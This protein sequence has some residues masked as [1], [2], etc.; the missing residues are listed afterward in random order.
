MKLPKFS[1]II[2]VK[3]EAKNLKKCL[4]TIRELNYP[5]E[6]IET[7]IADG[8][9]TDQTKIIA[10]KFK[11]RIVINKKKTVAPGRNRGFEKSH[12]Q[13]IAFTDA[14]CL[15]DKNWLKQSL[16]YFKN[17]KIAGVGGPNLTPDNEIDF[18]K[19]V[20]WV[21]NQKLFT[22]GSYHARIL[23][24]VTETESLPGCNAI[25]RREILEKVMPQDEDLLT[26]DETEMNYRIRD[27]GYRLL[28]TPDVFVWHYRKPTPKKLFIQMYRYAIGRLQLG[29]KRKDGMNLTHVLVG[30]TLPIFVTINILLLS[31][32]IKYFI[33]FYLLLAVYSLLLSIVSTIK[34]R[35]VIV[36]LY[37]II[38]V[39]II[40]VAWS[41]GFL[42]ELV[43]PIED[44]RG[45]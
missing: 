16:K 42:R 1:I 38:V 40:S 22:A 33:L 19:A 2:P 26:C 18:G 29:K 21:F 15:P 28:Y 11:A 13:Y 25:Y 9:S 6:K 3:N 24:K 37:T 31:I 35:N 27:L 12:G 34:N 30:L 7:I 43:F 39:V 32:N 41:V 8:L 44:I 45:K 4:L 20:S 5:K 23:Q 17:K 14:D 10:K 36:G